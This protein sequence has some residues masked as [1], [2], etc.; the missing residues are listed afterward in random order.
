MFEPYHK[1][2]R[3]F[4]NAMS[5]IT[6]NL[7]Q[8]VFSWG[9]VR[10]HCGTKDYYGSILIGSICDTSGFNYYYSPLIVLQPL[11]SRQ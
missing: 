8:A 7:S 2:K 1:N 5:Y 3:V 9:W 10:P 6:K 11:F 4:K